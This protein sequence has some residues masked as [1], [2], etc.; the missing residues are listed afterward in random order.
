L[1]GGCLL[2]GS[3]KMLASPPGIQFPM[4]SNTSYTAPFFQEQAKLP[5]YTLFG[6]I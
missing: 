3:P 5:T 2:Q 1:N 6:P 4:V